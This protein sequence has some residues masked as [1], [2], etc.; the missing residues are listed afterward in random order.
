MNAPHPTTSADASLPHVVIVGGGFAGLN[1]AKA[2]KKAP[3]RI[4]LIDRT[5]Y[6]L[7]QPLLYQVA[8]ASL[9]PADIAAPIRSVLRRQRNV[10]TLLGNVEAIDPKAKVV[11]VGDDRISYDYLILATGARHAY[12]GHPAWEARAP[13]LK[14]L[15]D[16]LEMRR[17]IF[18]AFEAAERERNPARRAALLTFVIVGGGPTGVELAGALGEIAHD[19]VRKDFRQIDTDQ[20]RIMLIDGGDRLLTTYSPK[21]SAAAKKQLEQL[22]VEVRLG[23][24]VTAVEERG[25]VLAN[26]ER[27]AA[28]TVL[29]AAGVVA[30]PLGRS[31]GVPLER[32]GQ[33]VVEPD[34]SVPGYPE[35]FIAG[36]LAAVYDDEGSP[37]PGVSPAAIQ[38]GKAVAANIQR[39]LA[40][41]PRKPFHYWDKGSM[42]TIGRHRGIA[43]VGRIELTGAIAWLGWLAVHIYF[44]IG[45]RNRL[46]VM[47]Q[48][49]W[50]YLTH[51]RSARLITPEWEPQTAA[52]QTAAAAQQ[53]AA[54]GGASAAR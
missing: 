46:L 42:A 27:I 20:A 52:R 54:R 53:P 28:E 26:G 44:L 29:W 4:T 31:L 48:W 8:T 50:A 36:D 13:G 18:R 47:A 5:N 41:K 19:V 45:F 33:V 22:G 11:T 12:F 37:V 49:A 30:S 7:F 17:R 40:G 2:L 39:S 51:N 9:S 3:V 16:A 10:T 38:E 34:L 35:I 32:T 43:A 15:D 25:V 1:A 14:G 23:K 6:H 24:L 21:L